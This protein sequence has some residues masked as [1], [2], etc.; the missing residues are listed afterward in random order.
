MGVLAG[1][2]RK[3]GYY[4]EQDDLLAKTK[5]FKHTKG[6]DVSILTRRNH[7]ERCLHQGILDPNLNQLANQIL[8]MTSYGV[9][10]IIGFSISSYSQ[11]LFALLLAERIKKNTKSV[12]VFGGAFITLQGYVFFPKYNFIDFMI[13]GNGEKPLLELLHVLQNGGLYENISGL[14]YRKNSVVK[15][16]PKERYDIENMP[17][18]D[19][20]GLDLNLYRDKSKAVD[21]ILLLPYQISKGCVHKC[22]FCVQRSLEKTNIKSFDKITR[23][24]K[25]YCEQYKSRHL[26]FSD[27]TLN[28]SYHHMDK[29]CDSFIANKLDIRWRGLARVDN[30]DERLLN[31]MKKAGCVSL[32]FGVESG[33][34]KILQLMKKGFNAEHSSKI[35][36]LTHKTGISV[37]LTIMVGFPQENKIDV[38]KTIE[39][40]KDNS[41]YISGIF[42]LNRFLLELNSPI[43]RNPEEFGV[44]NLGVR[45]DGLH[46]NYFSFDEIDGLR[47]KR[48][49]QQQRKAYQRV[50]K[51]VY[52][53]IFSKHSK[54][55]YLPF[56]LWLFLMKKRIIREIG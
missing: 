22:S 26:L 34:N 7:A 36:R 35:L 17:L 37:Y 43:Y 4:V 18:P 9:F 45:C 32:I 15:I 23:E 28:S 5:F 46:R 21:E 11:F 52:Y 13:T 41:R 38:D 16:T 47:W 1:V 20:D 31:K 44:T 24:I 42:S 29:L 56:L 40:L 50:L 48:K 10:D 27:W 14:L 8:K 53:N 25:C 39:F 49:M 51:V 6:I 33:S 54:R 12:I 19:F 2:L 30:L 3:N 55:P